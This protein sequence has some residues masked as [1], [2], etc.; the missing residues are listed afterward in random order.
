VS[1]EKTSLFRDHQG[2]INRYNLAAVARRPKRHFA[3]GHRAAPLDV[4]AICAD[5]SPRTKNSGRDGVSKAG[6]HFVATNSMKLSKILLKWPG[7]AQQV[8]MLEEIRRET[9][10][11]IIG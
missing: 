5:V 2:R 8:S 9:Y 6:E 11:S 10:Q 4:D 1:D 7:A 3:A